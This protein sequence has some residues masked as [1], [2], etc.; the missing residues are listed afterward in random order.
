[1][2]GAGHHIHGRKASVRIPRWAQLLVG[3]AFSAVGLFLFFRDVDLHALGR[4]LAATSL[5][6][7]AL[8]VAL[9]IASLWLRALRW[10]LM[11]PPTG[12][13]TTAGLFSTLCISF[14]VNNLLPAR[15]GEALRVLLVWRRNRYPLATAAG[16]VVLERLLD[17][18]VLFSF[19]CAPVA[20]GLA[21]RALAPYAVGMAA[22]GGVALALAAAYII[23]PA[24][25]L[26]ATQ[27]GVAVL[28]KRVRDRAA[29][30]VA[31]AFA[32]LAWLRSPARVFA[33]L[34][35]SYATLGCYAV[36]VM[37]LAPPGFGPLESAFGLAFAAFG[38][39]IPFSPG[40]VGTL[41]AAMLAGL[42]LLGM[43]RE[44]GVALAILYHALT[45]VPTTLIGLFY[46]FRTDL[47]FADLTRAKENVTPV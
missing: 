21:P 12:A 4:H 27:S 42:G 38:A 34:A 8:S 37:L 26:R 30:M 40:Y 25:L 35:L 9:T 20:L 6:A 11:L 44:A 33:M 36:I 3:L 41:H 15:A 18:G 16:S 5:S 10:R 24:P 39:A 29:G 22:A 28:P 1:V 19:F 46:F 7:V 31:Q 32:T 45:Y 13:S 43:Q 17:L 47:R 14:M 23:A 2:L